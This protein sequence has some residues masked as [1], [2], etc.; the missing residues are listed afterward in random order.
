MSRIEIEN[1]L[2]KNKNCSCEY[3]KPIL[4]FLKLIAI[5]SK[6]GHWFFEIAKL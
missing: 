6:T 2:S 4:D 3:R 5:L 1:P